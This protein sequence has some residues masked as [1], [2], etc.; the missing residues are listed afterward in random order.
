MGSQRRGVRRNTTQSITCGPEDTRPPRAAAPADPS[1]P[2]RV[3]TLA[4]GTKWL[5][6]LVARLNSY[7]VESDTST[8]RLILRFE[9]LTIPDQQPR[10]VSVRADAL[11]E[12]EEST[13]RALIS[14]PGRGRKVVMR[15]G[16]RA[17]RN[18]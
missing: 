14:R 7:D 16:G 18:R 13:L 3:I 5:A 12:M 6:T 1:A 17:S 2:A 11:E 8:S 9:C 15:G 10:I 4:G